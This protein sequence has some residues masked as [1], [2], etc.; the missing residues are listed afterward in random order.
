MNCIQTV[1]SIINACLNVF[2]FFLHIKYKGAFDLLAAHRKAGFKKS[3]S[4]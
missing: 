2:I 3:K 4:V 1:F